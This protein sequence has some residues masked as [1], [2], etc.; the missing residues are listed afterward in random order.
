MLNNGSLYRK[1]KQKVLGHLRTNGGVATKEEIQE[2][3]GV[4]SWAINQMVND[5]LYSSLNHN[6]KYVASKCFDYLSRFLTKPAFML[7]SE[8]HQFGIPREFFFKLFP[9]IL[10]VPTTYQSHTRIIAVHI[11]NLVR[12]RQGMKR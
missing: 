12:H 5:C 10:F 2:G 8:H 9:Q 11:S 7:L 3:I 6:G 4:P 1:K